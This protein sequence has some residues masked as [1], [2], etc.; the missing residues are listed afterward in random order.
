MKCDGCG[1]QFWARESTIDSTNV[2]GP[3]SKLP[4]TKLAWRVLCPECAASRASTYSFLYWT[5]GLLL[6]GGLIGMV[7][8]VVLSLFW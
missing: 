6:G 1:C 5:V 7:V 4:Y 3:G 8:Q 2:G